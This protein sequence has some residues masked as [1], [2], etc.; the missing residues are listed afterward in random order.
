MAKSA[1]RIDLGR[2]HAV[3]Q[4]YEQITT[5]KGLTHG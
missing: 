2:H 1:W 5:E 3:R 4:Q